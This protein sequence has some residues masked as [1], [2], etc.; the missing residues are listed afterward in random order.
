MVQTSRVFKSV[1]VVSAGSLLNAILGFGYLTGVAKILTIDD[2]GRYALLTGLLTLISK[3]LDF[4]T[5]SIFVANDKDDQKITADFLETKILL[6]LIALPVTFVTLYLLG[7]LQSDIV[8]IFILGLIA[9]GLNYTLYAFYQRKQSYFQLIAL[10]FVPAV[11]KGIIGVLLF[12]QVVQ[13]NLVMTFAVFSLSIFASLIVW[14][15]S[16]LKEYPISVDEQ[17][18][19]KNSFRNIEQSLSAGFSQLIYESWQ[20]INN[21]L[22]KFYNTFTDVGIFS[23][24]NKISNIFTLLSI[25]IFTVLLP[26]NAN[27]KKVASKSFDFKETALLAGAVFLFSFVMIIVAD[28]FM[29][30]AFGNKFAESVKFLDILILAG[31]VSATQNFLENYFYVVKKTKYLLTVNGI[32]IIA[33]VVMALVFIPIY[34]LYSLAMINFASSLIG[35]TL[36]LVVVINLEKSTRF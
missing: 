10:N 6:F 14:L 16:P 20:T 32:K 34:G 1:S 18:N 17:I 7:L 9:Y 26:K 15:L 2:F 12:T 35:L 29:H 4:G 31:A 22:I 28:N 30:L 23:M 36:L 11:L 19:L 3:I 8:V 27:L 5:N 24:A 21:V 13:M 25:A 33:L